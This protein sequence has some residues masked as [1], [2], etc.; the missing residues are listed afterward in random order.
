MTA[1]YLLTLIYTLTLQ[2]LILPIRIVR[3]IAYNLTLL[4]SIY[5]ANESGLLRSVSLT[6]YFG[7]I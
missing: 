1:I 2:P 5:K 3:F 7:G 4:A 6:Y